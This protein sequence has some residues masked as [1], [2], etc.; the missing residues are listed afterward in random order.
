MVQGLANQT[1][2]IYTANIVVFNVEP[3]IRYEW[4]SKSEVTFGKIDPEI[5]REFAK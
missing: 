4:V 3:V 5:I 1:H 2:R